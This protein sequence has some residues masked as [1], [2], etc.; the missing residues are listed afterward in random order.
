MDLS[1]TAVRALLFAAFAAATSI[2]AAI[3]GPTY[4]HLLVPELG[5]AALFPTL[6]SGGGTGFLANAAA[7]SSYLLTGLVDPAIALVAVALGGLYLLRAALG[8]SPPGFTDLLPRFVLAVLVANVTLPIAAGVLDLAGSAYGVVAAFDGGAWQSWQNLGGYGLVAYSWDNGALAFVVAFALFSLVL[9]L[10]AAVAVRNALLGVLLV[11]LPAFTL[12]WPI[13]WFAPLAARG[14]RWFLELAFLPCVLIV[15]LELAVGSPSVLLTLAYLTVALAS[16]SLVS[17]T[18]RSLDSAGWP[19]ASG[20][21]TGGVQRGL[22]AASVAVEGLVR[23]PVGGG[24]TS[25]GGG[26][27]LLAAAGRS[28]RAGAPLGL[29]AF[30][31]ELLGHGARGLLRH[32]TAARRTAPHGAPPGWRVR[33]FRPRGR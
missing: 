32:V 13:P 16:P 1:S 4:D 19:G 21:L 25:S 24:G 27:S 7:L 23:A 18:G 6:G 20:A 12:L 33:E 2:L 3:I 29:P 17:L 8:R 26:A 9:L 10:A 30:S 11:L 15:P 31:S 5:S 28:A 22:L 14:W